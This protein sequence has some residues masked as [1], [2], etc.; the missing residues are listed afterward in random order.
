MDQI[1][2]QIQILKQKQKPKQKQNQTQIHIQDT[3]YKNT[4][5]LVQCVYACS[6]IMGMMM[7]MT[8]LSR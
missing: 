6:S 4:L 7:M 3:R 5:I 8:Q 1:Q 2:I